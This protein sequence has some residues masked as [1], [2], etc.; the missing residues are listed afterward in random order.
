MQ[1]VQNEYF[2]SIFFFNLTQ[3]RC[4]GFVN[5]LAKFLPK[6]FEVME[7]IRRLTRKE[8]DQAFSNV[9]CPYLTSVWMKQEHQKDQCLQELSETILLGWPEKEEHALALTHPHFQHA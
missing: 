9:I 2:F 8:Q 1:T 3:C 5:Y 7:P 6:L 4:V